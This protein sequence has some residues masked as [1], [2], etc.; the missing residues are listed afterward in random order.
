VPS[1]ND[2]SALTT[3]GVPLKPPPSG[4]HVEP[5]HFA[6]RFAGTPPAFEKIPPA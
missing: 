6:M 3:P 4:D 5:F 2:R 1:S